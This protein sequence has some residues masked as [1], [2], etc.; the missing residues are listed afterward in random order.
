M[1]NQADGY[2][3]HQG[4]P[5]VTCAKII[6]QDPDRLRYAMSSAVWCGAPA[7]RATVGDERR[8]VSPLNVGH[9]FCD[10]HAPADAVLLP[11]K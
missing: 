11:T 8:P 6:G 2:T 4:E 5:H 3:Y 1:C 10:Q 7:T 9:F